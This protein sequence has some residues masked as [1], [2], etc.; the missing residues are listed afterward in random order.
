MEL[1]LFDDATTKK[2]KVC[3]LRKG[4]IFGIPFSFSWKFGLFVVL[5]DICWI[6]GKELKF[7]FLGI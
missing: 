4:V 2:E 3:W 5:I 7:G 6:C 1:A